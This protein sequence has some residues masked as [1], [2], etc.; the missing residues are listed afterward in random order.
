MRGAKVSGHESR[1]A[2]FGGTA[3]ND[4][5]KASLLG[6]NGIERGNQTANGEPLQVR[7]KLDRTTYSG[8]L[9]ANRV[10]S[11]IGRSLPS[12]ST[13]PGWATGMIHVKM[14]RN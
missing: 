5:R 14:A 8:Y 2:G 10:R 3:L 13:G 11:V 12:P 1:V 4:D 6:K 7:W 9:Y